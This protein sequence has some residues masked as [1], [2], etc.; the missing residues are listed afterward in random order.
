MVALV[1]G[2]G[3]PGVTTAAVALGAIWPR[4]VLVAECD[5]A[6]SDFV[7]RYSAADRGRLSQDRGVVSLATAARSGAAAG[8]DVWSHVQTLDGGLPVLVGAASPA[9]VASIGWSWPSMAGL[10]AGLSDA[11]VLV[12][13]GRLTPN[14]PALEFLALADVVVM[15]VRPTAEGAAHASSALMSLDA[16]FRAAPASPV[17]SVTAPVAAR[18][19]PE[20]C[21]VVVTPK[22]DSKDHV[23]QVQDAL[24]SLHT[25]APVIGHL[26]WDVPA[27]AGLRGQWTRKLDKSALITS[28]RTLATILDGRVA[29]RTWQ[30][31]DSAAAERTAVSS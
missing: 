28:A 8:V 26:A 2:K 31:D 12:D 23:S 1:A 5:A 3:C 27:A 17:R 30:P 24:T 6:G 29:A 11:D 14:S 19:Q 4:P 25:P 22:G 9:Q 13:C 18:A 16:Q 15:L 21:V 20:L 10:L 7:Y